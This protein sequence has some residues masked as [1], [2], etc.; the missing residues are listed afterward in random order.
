MFT[1]VTACMLA[2]LPKAT[3][4]I[5]GFRRFVAS[6]SAPIATGWSNPL[7]GGILTH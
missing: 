5:G 1:R 2:E 6:T 4:Y 7:P 3:R